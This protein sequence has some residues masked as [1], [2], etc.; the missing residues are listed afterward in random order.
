MDFNIKKITKEEY[1]NS[2]AFDIV[3]NGVGE[4]YANNIFPND[5]EE[6]LCLICEI[7]NQIVAFSCGY[8]FVSEKYIKKN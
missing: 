1:Y 6:P 3:L 4:T 7:N 8:N 5:I 2:K